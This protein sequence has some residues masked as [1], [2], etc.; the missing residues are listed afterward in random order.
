[1]F[2]YDSAQSDLIPVVIFAAAPTRPTASPHVAIIARPRSTWPITATSNSSWICS[3]TRPS[4]TSST[5]FIHIRLRGRRRPSVRHRRGDRLVRR[6]HLA[7]KIAAE[8]VAMPAS[9]RARD[10]I[11]PYSPLR[12][13]ARRPTA[14][15]PARIAPRRL[16][17]FRRTLPEFPGLPGSSKRSLS[18]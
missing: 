6:A 7:G 9:D 14:C 13:A 4:T 11:R 18:A 15:A 3:R 8:F 5:I 12:R 2:A 1:M 10:R 17:K 16:R